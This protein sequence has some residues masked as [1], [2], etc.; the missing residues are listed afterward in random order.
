MRGERGTLPSKANVRRLFRGRTRAGKGGDLG[1]KQSWTG[2]RTR[3]DRRTRGT[4]GLGWGQSAEV[5][6][7][8]PSPSSESSSYTRAHLRTKTCDRKSFLQFWKWELSE[9]LWKLS[10]NCYYPGECRSLMIK[11]GK[12]SAISV[13]EHRPQGRRLGVNYTFL[14]FYEFLRFLLP[15]PWIR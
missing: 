2:Y 5:T 3:Q 12:S 9:S 10:E 1:I 4:Q 13:L 7:E 14:D 8:K 6:Q 15:L 11:A